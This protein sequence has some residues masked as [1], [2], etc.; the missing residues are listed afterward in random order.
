MRQAPAD[1]LPRLRYDHHP[2][3]A[4]E[5]S[6]ERLARYSQAPDHRVC[7]GVGLGQVLPVFSTIAAES[8]RLINETY[9]AFVHQFMPHYGQPDADMLKN[10]SAAIIVNT[11]ETS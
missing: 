11:P 4:G 3:R 2:R 9:P 5:Q 6:Q 7:R 8:K 1:G 10:I